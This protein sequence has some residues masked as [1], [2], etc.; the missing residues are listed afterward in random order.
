[1]R[2][3]LLYY[4]VISRFILQNNSLFVILTKRV[5]LH[6]IFYRKFLYYESL[7][8]FCICKNSNTE[9]M[10]LNKDYV[11]KYYMNGWRENN[12]LKNRS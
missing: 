3:D 4:I 10:N 7:Y 9:S 12:S 6:L 1:M 8:V 11:W 2:D 5:K